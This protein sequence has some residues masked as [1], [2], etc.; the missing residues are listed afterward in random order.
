MKAIF[1]IS[2]LEED[3]IIN[4][5][6][7]LIN[8]K[9]YEVNEPVTNRFNIYLIDK[10]ENGQE[11]LFPMNWFTDLNQYRNSKLESIGI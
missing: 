4:V 5:E 3:D 2:K 6:G 7:L 10:T 11:G 1:D 9:I 8:G